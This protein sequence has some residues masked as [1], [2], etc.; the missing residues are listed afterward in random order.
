LIVF[1]EGTTSNSRFVT[2]FKRGAFS[3]GAVVSP[4]C[5]RYPNKHYDLYLDESMLW[6]LYWAL[7]QFI[8][9]AHYEYLPEYEPTEEEKRDPT[10]LAKN[11]RA[12]I[13]TTLGA[14]TTEHDLSDSLLS[15]TAA[16]EH[17]KVNFIVADLHKIVHAD[18]G[19]LRR[20]MKVYKSWDQDRNGFLNVNEFAEGL[21]LNGSSAIAR[22]LF[23]L[24]DT[25]NDGQIDFAEFL[26]AVGLSHS[27]RSLPKDS[28]KILFEICDLNADMCVTKE[29]LKKA[30]S[31]DCVSGPVDRALIEATLRIEHHEHHEHHEGKEDEKKEKA[32]VHVTEEDVSKVL[33]SDQ[34]DAVV[35]TDFVDRLAHHPLIMEGMFHLFIWQRAPQDVK[36]TVGLHQ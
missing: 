24:F 4:V 27:P 8:N 19:D 3:T 36:V 5:I 17:V 22:R 1:P 20:L 31:L 33:F 6:S 32:P 34:Q 12:L 16:K 10:L 23:D 29:E 2:M 26:V 21:G 15:I 30:M 9:Y 28:A 11:I 13:A 18:A 25:D 7:C 35:F 14:E